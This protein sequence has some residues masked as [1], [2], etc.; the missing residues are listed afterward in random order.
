MTI[1]TPEMPP[2]VEQDAE[3]EPAEPPIYYCISFDRLA[4][5]LNR[6]AVVLLSSRSGSRQPADPESADPQAL[7]DDIAEYD[8]PDDGFIQPSMT[9]QEIL[10]R[11]FL[12]R[13]N[14][15]MSLAELRRELTEKW[16][17][18][19]RP[20]SLTPAGL[21]RILDHDHYYGFARRDP[22]AAAE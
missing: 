16:S 2:A 1:P 13:R 20:I 8:A 6:S 5:E 3:A 11:T 4:N 19:D 10:F 18:P 14:A 17:F 7:L 9:V 12:A 22:A 21:Q 15:P